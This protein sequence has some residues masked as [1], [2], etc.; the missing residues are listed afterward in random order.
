MATHNLAS[1]SDERSVDRFAYFSCLLALAG[2][3]SA[4]EER[5]DTGAPPLTKPEAVLFDALPVV[6]AASL[7]T[8][9]LMEAPASVTVITDEDIRRRGY[10][11]LGEA[12]SDARG[13]GLFITYDRTYQG[14]G[15][16][17]YAIPGD[18]STR[19]MI[20]INGHSMSESLYVTA[21]SFG[22]DFGLDMDVVKRIEIIRGPSSALYGN[23]G[24]FATINIVTKSP[25][26]YQ[27]LR[28]TA[29]TGSFGQRKLEVG[30]S[31]YLG[32]GANLLVAAS[33]FNNTGQ[34]LYFPQFDSP[35]TNSG[36]AVNMDGERG[37]HTFADLI[38]GNWSFLGYLA[39]REKIVPTAW[40][41]AAFN[42]RGTSVAGTRGFADASYQRNLGASGQLRWRTFYDEYHTVNR[43]DFTNASP[44]LQLLQFALAPPVDGRQGGDGER[45]GSEVDYRFQLPRLG[46][47]TIGTESNWDI[48]AK[49][50]AE[51]VAPLH[52]PISEVDTLGR[53]FAVFAQQEWEFSPRWKMYLGGRLDMARYHDRAV[54]PR[55]GLIYQPSPA[56]A[57]KLLFGRAFRNPSVFEQFYHDG[58]TQIE[59]PGLKSER[60]NSFEA[61]FE[62]RVGRTVDLSANV[63]HYDLNDVIAEVPQRGNAPVPKRE[64]GS[65]A[66]V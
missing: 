53:S 48:L 27:P 58:G 46:Y 55:I 62:K 15:V 43:V 29:E 49:L 24:M 5:P 21:G 25:V 23:K 16:R 39:G 44:V 40:Y 13:R 19:L 38:W 63:Y 36:W 66:R 41:G 51:L 33:V 30:T 52:L 60:M 45:L 56:S 28:V 6:E 65:I 47:V 32:R 50:S 11:T 59:N 54:S 8:Q 17:G 34:S 12:L 3:S 1:R 57:V 37:Y 64:F 61:V 2:I 22:Q 35:A 26:E 18:Y 4:Q 31:Q 42:D 9:S 20:M 7:H 14:L 10:R